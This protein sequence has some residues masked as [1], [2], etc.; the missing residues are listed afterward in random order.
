MTDLNKFI[1]EELTKR[2]ADYLSSPTY[3]IEHYESEKQNIQAY[4]GR[5][6]LEM[7]QNADDASEK[8][9]T[10]KKVLIELKDNVLTIANNGE[11][12][13]EDSF[14][15]ILYSS[16]SPKTLQQNKIGQK[17]LGFRSILSW[18]DEVIINSGGT[19]LAF[20]EKIAKSFLKS[21]LKESEELSNF[22]KLKSKSKM[23]IATLR[24]PMVLNGDND[25]DN[26]FDTII[27]IKL[28]ENIIDDVQSQIFSVINKETLIFL[29]NIETIVI[30]SPKRRIT[31]KKS[32]TD[33]TKNRVTVESVNILDNI[34]E[35]KTW[36]IKKRSGT[37]KEKNYELSIAWNDELDE[38]EN[39]LF[40]YFKT[41][42]RFPFPAL[43]H[44]TFELAQSRNQ[45]V[46]DT[47]GHNEF[48]TGEL[49]ELLIETALEIASTK[50]EA[51]YLPLKLL[52]IEFDK[53][54]NVLQQFNF[55]ETL[56]DK[57]KSSNIFP[58]INNFYNAY[59]AKPVF[60]DHPVALIVHGDDVDDLMPICNDES[61]VTFIK[62]FEISHYTVKYFISI[63][64]KRAT[65]LEVRELA[66][67]FYYF[68]EYEPYNEELN[69]DNFELSELDEFLLDYENNIINWDANIFIQPQ[70]NR[71]FKLP[72][73]LNIRF[74]NQDFVDALLQEYKTDNIDIILNK[75]MPFGIRKY[76]FAE[77]SETLIQHFNSKDKIERKDIII[78]HKYL[79]LLFKSELKSGQPLRLSSEIDTPVISR[80][81]KIKTAKEVYFGK[82]FGNMLTEQLYKHD[83]SKLLAHP[84]EFGLE[85]AKD[86]QLQS[87][88]N[89]LG[90]AE[91]PRKIITDAPKEFAEYAFRRFD[92]KNR[93]GEY[94]LSN[95]EKFKSSRNRYG[96]VIIQS[97]DDIEG[98]LT[99]NN[100][101]SII[102]WLCA[103]ES[104]YKLLE[105]DC[106]PEESLI[107]VLLGSDRNY[108]G[109]YGNH[110][111]NFLKWQ[112]S[113]FI[114]LKTKSGIKQAPILCTTSATISAEFSPLIEKPNIDYDAHIL[115]DNNINP[116]KVDYLLHL[117]GVNK[118]I[119]SFETK[120]LYSILNN[121]PEI[122]SEGKKA[123]TL[124][125]EL[126]VNYDDRNLDIS[127]AEYKKFIIKGK[128]F[129]SKHGE[130][131][132]E[133]TTSVFYVDS[134]RYGESIISQFNTI[135]IERRRSREKIEKV[136]GVKPLK[137]L[138]LSLANNPTLH[139][140]N[141]KFE[142]EIESFKPY[143]YVFRQ[144]MD[145]TGKEKN[146]IKDVRFKLVTDL[147]VLLE[148]ENE[149]TA[150][151][152][153]LYE[154]LYL[155][156]NKIVYI[157]TPEYLD[158]ERKLKEDINFCSTIAEAFSALIDVDAQ[159]QQIRELFS[160][161]ASIRDDIIRAEL[162]DKKLERLVFA[163]E[164]L[165]ITNDPKIH[166]WLAYLKCFPAKKFRKDR[167]TDEELLNELRKYLPNLS[168]TIS[169]SFDK[170]NYEDYNEEVSLR[171]IVDLLTK[172]NL[173]LRDFNRYAYPS[174]DISELYDLD[175]KRIRE[176]RKID[177]KKALYSML[178]NSER[179][180]KDFLKV[181]YQYDA[182]KG[183]FHNEINYN[184]ETDL[185]TLIR[186]HFNIEL[187]DMID[188]NFEQIYSLNKTAYENK[189]EEH[190][191]SKELANQFLNEYPELENL[192]YFE[193]EVNTL[194]E[195]FKDW[196][197]TSSKGGT[198]IAE[199]FAKKN[200]I[201]IGDSAIFYDN[202]ADLFNQLETDD[203]FQTNLS[204]IKIKKAE[205][206]NFYSNKDK[207]PLNKLP[208]KPKKPSEDLGF[209][210]EWLA[211]K[212][213]LS[214]VKNKESIKWV[215]EYAK[216]AGVNVDG[217]DGLGYDMEY[218]PNDAKYP[219]YVEVKVVGWENA[220][221]ISS[222]EINRGEKLKK[223]YE[224]F[225]VR[226][227]VEPAN[228]LIEIIQGPFDYKGQRSFTD[229]D[230]FTVINDS[231]ILKFEKTDV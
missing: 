148:R 5:Q 162:D 4:N 55:K 10:E 13:N 185:N 15:S 31:F 78:L 95:Y 128:V 58:S 210:G 34:T 53:V 144:D 70:D 54:D 117:V 197:P 35:S 171:L 99:K 91:L 44:G 188:I 82:H 139:Y 146:L 23:P 198:G 40:S 200:R 38:N 97:I 63:I 45:L 159:R 211:Y 151:S 130:F 164:K 24:V 105:N 194:I 41:E 88:F 36:N 214:T 119:S 179:D 195:R 47:D 8:K 190:Q 90:V 14:R 150:F 37:H 21:L 64:A 18:A 183:S 177:F 112:L 115:K 140:L 222:N 225:L 51:N 116:D 223:H 209:L 68:L 27:S 145:T 106:E 98:I 169:D 138:R 39:V 160:K 192:L 108:R 61:V 120:T 191:I 136:F 66:K 147:N 96:K 72:K 163:K 84:Q 207:K 86:S 76:S 217:K 193:N 175:F 153:S 155:A 50:I 101:E 100:C 46:N 80:T 48:L 157:R 85:D 221:H 129:C 166:F 172:S 71:E 94:H 7:L 178:I 137:G 131:G 216:L 149:K 124:Y 28:K 83:K 161:S 141:G 181:L 123:R 230:L 93:I 143:V 9:A 56:I 69:S 127:E 133:N 75:L 67:L 215:S 87:Y 32:Y 224:I 43:L 202:F 182:L 220:F 25:S 173:S 19:K 30:D 168:K 29:N 189:A 57:I 79:F 81:M 52:N 180:R 218:I 111:R 186:E 205:A 118:T 165:G 12:F 26:N 219:R 142:Q 113:N 77:I 228:I 156:K 126:A 184:V 20:S 92:Y 102:A 17:G 104:I 49:A 227:L 114:W 174:I 176:S 213:L 110:I 201:N 103:D 107:E 3:L 203:I 122:D 229:N 59:A 65:K 212:H 109:I 1:E 132:Y 208:K 6:L 42:V 74:L 89:W 170:I 11:P 154:Y 60:Y 206:S 73:L 196:M 62:T 121:L 226:N 135:V 152:L 204:K 2:K 231:F 187:T 33:K 199:G 134:K 125:R 167:I 16:V 22:I 158:D